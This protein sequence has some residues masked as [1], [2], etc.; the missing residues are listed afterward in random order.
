MSLTPRIDRLDRNFIIN[1]GMDYF[2]RGGV[3]AA[4][5]LGTSFDYITADRFDMRVTGTWTTP[6]SGRSSTQL[7]DVARYSHLFQGTPTALGD[8]FVKRQKIESVFAK[9]LVDEKISL[10]LLY[11]GNNFTTLTITMYTADVEDDFSAVTQVDQKVIT[12][13][14]DSTVNQAVWEDIPT[15][16]GATRGLMIEFEFSGL[17]A[18]S[19]TNLY[20]GEIKLNIGSDVQDFGYFNS[21]PISELDICQRYFTKTYKI[22][23]DVGTITNNNNMIMNG[24]TINLGVAPI[25]PFVFPVIMRTVPSITHYHPFNGSATSVFVRDD[26]S[27]TSTIAS[28]QISELSYSANSDGGTSGYVYITH[29]TADAEL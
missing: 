25:R 24:L 29:A 3:S 5:A 22:N 19:A 14:D 28:A 4:V 23:D 10:A 15:A 12:I 7:G 1:G 21:D 20:T 6:T 2:Q 9:E 17:G 11:S 13:L 26:N 8:T 27:N 18:L 16:S